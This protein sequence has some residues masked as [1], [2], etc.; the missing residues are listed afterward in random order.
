ML[1]FGSFYIADFNELLKHYNDEDKL[2]FVIIHPICIEPTNIY[3]ILFAEKDNTGVVYFEQMY[4]LIQNMKLRGKTY[5]F[6][7][8]DH[9]G[10]VLEI[11]TKKL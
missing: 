8:C 9:K 3:I 6:L 7:D 11:I 10:N 5:K 2:I 4:K 1:S